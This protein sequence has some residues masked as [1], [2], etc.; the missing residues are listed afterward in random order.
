METNNPQNSYDYF[1]AAT[2]A[3]PLD[4]FFAA[5]EKGEKI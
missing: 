2:E 1:Y 3:K 5:I 4:L